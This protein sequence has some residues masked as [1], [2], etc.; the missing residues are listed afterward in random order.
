MPKYAF[1]FLLT[2][3]VSLSAYAAEPKPLE[4]GPKD[5]CPVCGMFVSKYHDFIA[6]LSLRD[7]TKLYF[8][9]AKDLF[10]FRLDM[11]RYLPGKSEK[12][13]V[14]V[15]VKEYYSLSPVD[16]LKAYYVLGSDVYGPMGKELIP[17]REKKEAQEFM[18][19]HRGKRIVR[20]DEVTATMLKE[21]D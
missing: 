18:K 6:Q 15:Y 4:P 2:V 1:I 9:G 8:D 12:E 13:I 17:F 21:L 20:F 7:G 14:A 3:C 16:A 19:D 11:Q 10:K 5:K